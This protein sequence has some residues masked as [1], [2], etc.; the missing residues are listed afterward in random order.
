MSEFQEWLLYEWKCNVFPPV[1]VSTASTKIDIMN[2][3]TVSMCDLLRAKFLCKQQALGVSPVDIA[4]PVTRIQSLNPAAIYF[5]T[6]QT[7]K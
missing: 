2:I 3:Y 6:L 5:T 1:C 7:Y 4:V